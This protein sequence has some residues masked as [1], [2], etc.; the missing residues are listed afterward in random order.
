MTYMIQG[1]FS[2]ENINVT[3]YEARLYELCNSYSGE[4]IHVDYENMNMSESNDNYRRNNKSKPMFRGTLEVRFH[5]I[6]NLSA[7]SITVQCQQMPTTI[8]IDKLCKCLRQ[9]QRNKVIIDMIYDE[10][11]NVSL[12]KS[13]QI[14][15]QSY[16]DYES[17][18]SKQS[19][20]SK[21]TEHTEHTE[22]TSNRTDKN[23]RNR[24]YTESEIL[25]LNS[26]KKKSFGVPSYD[27]Y[28]KSL[29]K[30]VPSTSSEKIQTTP[31]NTPLHSRP[32]SPD[33]SAM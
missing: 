11:K 22:Q 33:G 23:K 4:N 32:S 14:R 2:I 29:S 13:L 17:Y 31:N 24:A 8:S 10:N 26:L 15:K 3:D 9:L 18:K 27:E 25:L 30:L 5:T 28:L 16:G 20:Q 21:H 1:S 12:Y 6:P 19:K 7:Q